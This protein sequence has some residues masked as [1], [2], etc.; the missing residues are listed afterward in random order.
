MRGAHPER[1]LERHVAECVKALPGETLLAAASGGADSVALA[2]LLSAHAAEVGA[3]VV[4]AHVNHR[5]RSSSEQD[6]AV[7]LSVGTALRARVAVRSLPQGTSDEARLREGR[8]AALSEI[9]REVGARR[10]FA[11]H[12]AQ[13]Q[14]ETVLL[15]LFRGAG[16]EALRGMPARRKLEED[17]VL[18][19]PLLRVRREE[20]TAY[21]AGR[22]LPFVFDASNLD[23]RYRRNVLRRALA[24]L[25]ESFPRLDEAV[26]RCAEIAS[27]EA[28]QTKR[29]KLRAF[30]RERLSEA[31][32][33]GKALRD[34]P[35][36]RLD[37]VARALEAGRSG[38]HFLK[39]GVHAEL[40]ADACLVVDAAAV[41]AEGGA[42]IDAPA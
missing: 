25:R 2:A 21:C 31:L 33:P 30:V 3:T 35:F 10:V 41:D 19:R 4:L 17:L 5:T 38:R 11:A 28:E 16:P 29:A 14:T 18:E 12:H 24:D 36:E 6:E 39:P 26:A 13:D 34:V 7:V 37:A 20:L 42:F 32:P 8:Y 15:A 22:R 9:A 27:D 23:R 1:A 40:S